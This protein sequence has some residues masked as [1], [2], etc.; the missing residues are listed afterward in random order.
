MS[1]SLKAV[2]V[3]L[4]LG[5]A[6]TSL[7]FAYTGSDQSDAAPSVA[8]TPEP[9]PSPT[10][11]PPPEP[12]PSP[13]PTPSTDAPE[14]PAP[15]PLPT[16]TEAAPSE[17][18][19]SA[20]EEGA[21]GLDVTAE[22]VPASIEVGD[23]TTISARVTNSGEEVEEDLEVGVVLPGALEFVSSNPS[24]A[25]VHEDPNSTFVGF[26]LGDLA[27]GDSVDVSVTAAALE[28]DESVTVSVE[29]R[30]A[31][32]T[33]FDTATVEID[34][35][36][37]ALLVTSRATDLLS[38]V[39]GGA[40]F[41]VTVTNIGDAV[42]KNVSVVELVAPELHV[43]SAALPSGVD[44]VQVGRSGRREDIVWIINDLDEDEAI[45]LKWSA[46]V[47]SAGD[48]AATSSVTATADNS[49]PA[50]AES[51]SY[52]ARDSG[53]GVE[54]PKVEVRT[55]RVVR[56]ERVVDRPLIRKR[57][58]SDSVPAGATVLP[59]TG[60]DP[61]GI[62]TVA[63]GLILTG[64]ALLRIASRR[65]EP[66]RL[67]AAA[68]LLVL[69]ATACVSNDGGER[70]APEV[71]PRVK[72]RQ[73][74]R[75]DRPGDDQG[76][77]GAEAG[78][79][80]GAQPGAPPDAADDTGP[81][82]PDAGDGTGPTTDGLD[83]PDEVVVLVPG[84]PEVR[85]VRRVRVETIGA[86]DLPVAEVGS[87]GSGPATFTWNDAAGAL[88]SATSSRTGTDLARVAT[89][90]ADGG[91]G[92]TA[93]VTLKNISTRTRLAV[94]G[95]LS[96]RLSGGVSEILTTT[97]SERVLNPGGEVSESFTFRLPSGTYGARALYR[98]S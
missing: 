14:S 37:G 10:P 72:G 25:R 63:V 54:N 65:V 18:P 87:L 83:D 86:T 84:E 5:A 36:D 4:V 55:K 67:T 52:M 19:A 59:F 23:Q 61:W 34:E 12:D 53:G 22:A 11:E 13:S 42:L 80:D 44:A 31:A 7:P 58:P 98:S 96:L 77:P 92:I 85:F 17:G 69:V 78:D 90:L 56:R 73:I 41:V 46:I 70:A 89:T 38:E 45:T 76:D 20:G 88:G 94:G 1:R 2:I 26:T 95:R 64:A 66:K 75:G 30:S 9:G 97:V 15:D 93:T 47:E 81:A 28:A 33:A 43:V 74:E 49:P 60:I 48:L 71:S 16:P 51:T 62:A 40:S 79:D 6:L 3:A 50:S 21:R 68:F 35:P 39:G 8:T 57:V 82:A 91:P 24:G 27:P 29:A 32:L